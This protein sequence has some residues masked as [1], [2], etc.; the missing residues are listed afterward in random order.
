[1]D[2]VIGCRPRLGD[3][4][5]QPYRRAPERF[6]EHCHLAGE[7][8]N[9]LRQPASE[10]AAGRYE[11]DTYPLRILSGSDRA[12]PE[13]H[14]RSSHAIASMQQESQEDYSQRAYL[15]YV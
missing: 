6:G 1:M 13:P 11:S 3:G 15:P 4:R 7:V 2:L 14:W 8:T 9:Q 12:L 10:A 5:P